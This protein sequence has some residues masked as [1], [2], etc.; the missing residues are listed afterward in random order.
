MPFLWM[1]GA[2]KSALEGEIDS[3][4]N[5]NIRAF[6]VES[7]THPDFCGEGWWRDLRFVIDK[8]KQL[9][10]KLWI[11]DDAHFPTGF[12]NGAVKAAQAL[13]TRPAGFYTIEELLF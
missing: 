11:L 5:N 1:Q 12:A 10:L 6:I 13:S 9:G 3:I 8:C 2:E 7:R 4:Y